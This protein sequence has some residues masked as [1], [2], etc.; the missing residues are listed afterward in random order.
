MGIALSNALGMAFIDGDDLHPPSNIAKM[1]AGE[2][3]TDTDRAPWL[4]R[5]RETAQSRII[6]EEATAGHMH[7][8]G[9]GVVVACSS[10]K[11]KYRNVLRGDSPENV[12]TIFVFI[13]GS[14]EALIERIE[15][16]KGH[17]MKAKML[18]S[19]LSTLEDPRDETGVISVPMEDSTE[20]QVLTVIEQLNQI[21]GP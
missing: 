14:R 11:K 17:F 20:T 21:I 7:A 1:T 5:I 8:V 9:P 13:S 3:L 15:K 10:L 12:Q 6:F 4:V 19:Q 18:E 2:P 16:R